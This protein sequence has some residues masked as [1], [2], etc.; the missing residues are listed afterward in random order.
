MLFGKT[1][2]HPE[3]NE[4]LKKRI[5][6]IATCE[7]YRDYDVI[8][9]EPTEL[10]WNIFPGFTTLQFYGKVIDL[11]SSVG[12]IPETISGRILSMSMLNDISCDRK[13]NKR[14]FGK[15][16]S[17]LVFAKKFGIGQ[18]SFIYPGSEKKLSS[19]EETGPQGIWDHIEDE[20][21]LE[22]AESGCLFSVSRLHCSWR[23]TQEQR[24]RKTV[25]TFYC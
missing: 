19:V 20:I 8:S 11:L 4:A 21:L 18:L 22:F 2:Q 12:Q 23:K 25:D 15:C 3:S 17:R 10:E 1:Q 9:G 7:S 16:Q 13:G 24:T 6:W 14:M 5:E